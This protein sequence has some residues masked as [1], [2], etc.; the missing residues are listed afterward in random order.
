MYPM[1]LWRIQSCSRLRQNCPSLVDEM[2]TVSLPALQVPTMIDSRDRL[3]TDCWIK[4]TK[5]GL[6]HSEADE[7]A[8]TIFSVKPPL[9]PL[10]NP[11]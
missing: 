2:W 7:R 3:I 1:W 4:A 5:F 8:Q 10:K 6:S 9:V 11:S